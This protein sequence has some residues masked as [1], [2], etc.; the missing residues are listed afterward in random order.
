MS[1]PD[2]RDSEDL[3]WSGLR[4]ARASFGPPRRRI[5]DFADMRAQPVEP[6]EP[7]LPFENLDQL[8]NFIPFG[9]LK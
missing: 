3:D 2:R 6:A 5:E 8:D 9:R 7:I 4:A 1:N